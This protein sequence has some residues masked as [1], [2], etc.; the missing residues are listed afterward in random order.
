MKPIFIHALLVGAG[1]FLG[2][3]LR[4]LTSVF[5][6]RQFPAATFPWATFSVN[7]VGCLLIGVLAGY[8]D[9]KAPAS[10][11]LRVFLM[12]GLLG[13]FT[14]FSAFGFETFAMLRNEAYLSAV[15]NAGLQV[16]LGVLLV[17][18]GYAIARP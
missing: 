14:T 3:L 11:E 1:G 5:V 18:A 16:V 9:G 15:A 17:W 6:L 8:A 13:G 4:Y 10:S 12:V 7:L 2:A